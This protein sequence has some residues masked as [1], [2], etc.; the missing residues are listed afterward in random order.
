MT[1]RKHP[2]KRPGH[3]RLAYHLAPPIMF[4]VWLAACIEFPILL[5]VTAVVI[6]A[7]LLVKGQS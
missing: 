6:G 7:T 4:V 5:A 3:D 1:E 2:Y